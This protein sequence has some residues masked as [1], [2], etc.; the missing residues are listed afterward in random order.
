[1]VLIDATRHLLKDDK[2]FKLN[3][4]LLSEN[5]TVTCCS[6]K[7]KRQHGYKV[8]S[9]SR[10]YYNT[11]HSTK[12]DTTLPKK[13]IVFYL[14]TDLQL[15]DKIAVNNWLTGDCKIY[16]MF[17]NQSESSNICLYKTV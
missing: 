16:I 5:T 13:N 7:E 11:K 2:G 4:Y 12:R 17:D 8:A 14:L 1:M 15:Q 3:P 9:L 10:T 6:W